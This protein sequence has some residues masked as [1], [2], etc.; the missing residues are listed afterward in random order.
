MHPQFGFK[1]HIEFTRE[2]GSRLT[3]ESAIEVLQ[4]ERLEKN[5]SK[6]YVCGPPSQNIM[7]YELRD[8]I[9]DIVGVSE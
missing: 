8:T 2:G 4:K 6:I 9:R 7:F 3:K 5:I 1:I